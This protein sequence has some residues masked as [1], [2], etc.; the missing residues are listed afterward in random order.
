MLPELESIE[1][2]T[3]PTK[4]Q[5]NL[6][7]DLDLDGMVV[8]A[9][10]SD[11]ATQEVTDYEVSGYDKNTVGHQ[12]I[13]VTYE[14]KTAEF[15]VNVVDPNKPT[16]TISASLAA[17]TYE[18]V[19]SVTLSTV[20]EDATI[21]YTINGS[22]PSEE[23]S[24]EYT[25]TISISETTT[26]KAFAVKEGYNDS[27]QLVAEYIIILLFTSAPELTLEPDSGKIT[28]TWTDSDPAAD[29]YDVYYIEGDG[30]TAAQVKASTTKI[31]GATSGGVI[32]GLTNDTAY[33]VI[34]TAHKE[35]YTSIDSAVGS[36]TPSPPY[37]ITGSSASFTATQSGVT[38]GTADQAIQ[39]VIDAIKTHANGK[40]II[41]QFGD[42]NAVLDIAGASVSFNTTSGT[43]GLIELSG[44]ITGSSTTATSGTIVTGNDVS[45]NS[46][47][48]IANTAASVDAKAIYNNSTGTLTISGGE[49]K[50]NTG[51]AIQNNTTGTIIVSGTAKLT[52]ANV[53]TSSGTIHIVS[54]GTGGDRLKI[55]GGTVENTAANGNAIYNASTGA[56]IISGGIVQVTQSNAYAIYNNS[57]GSLT[58]T[59]GTVSATT[60]QAAQ[61]QL[62]RATRFTTNRER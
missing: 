34:V 26:L 33:S 32:T 11:G 16:V 25:T 35:G 44:K 23:E 56:V 60:G 24:E 50:A 54:S 37:V 2:T 28:Y 5:Y 17:G 51:K 59:G 38:I 3:P 27:N 21:Y 42:G 9:T 6:G 55:E 45:V 18:G 46:T 8:K 52:S 40:N 13:T 29:S 15:S 10:Y 53:T 61:L 57:T 39:S 47:A 36:A 62:Q 7:E 4:T 31:I 14:D 19:Q 58:I 20:P 1:I 22:E 12:P 41:I 48:D 49:V 43:W 30:K